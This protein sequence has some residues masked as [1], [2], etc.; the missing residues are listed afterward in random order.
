MLAQQHLSDRNLFLC[1][2]DEDRE[3][4]WQCLKYFTGEYIIHVGELI[5]TATL[6][7]G[8][9]AP[10]GRTTTSSFQVELMASFHCL[11]TLSLP[12]FPF[13]RDCLTV[14][15]RTKWVTGR[16]GEDD[17]CWADIPPD[18]ILPH[19]RACPQLQFLLSNNNR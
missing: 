2:P 8:E 9:Q 7:G 1:Y 19:T 4:A 5:S 13:S 15:K 10:F 12:G 16:S 11:L 14:W 6:S 17:D 3:L 18:E